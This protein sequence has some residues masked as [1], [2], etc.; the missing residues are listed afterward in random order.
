MLITYLK[1]LKISARRYNSLIWFICIFSIISWHIRFFTQCFLFSSLKQS[2]S[3]YFN[4]EVIVLTWMTSSDFYFLFKMISLK[5]RV[6]LLSFFQTF[7]IS[8]QQV[9]VHLKFD[10]NNSI[11]NNKNQWHGWYHF[12]F[13]A[14]ITKLI[15]LFFAFS[16]DEALRPYIVAI[17]SLSFLLGLTWLIVALVVIYKTRYRY[18]HQ[19]SKHGKESIELEEAPNLIQQYDDVHHMVVDTWSAEYEPRLRW[20]TGYGCRRKLHG[21][22]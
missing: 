22:K 10:E 17:S 4:V 20:W 21:Y 6:F 1:F 2:T 8:K 16:D 19:K 3:N 9:Y 13:K 11:W 7:T 5:N 15:E 12:F 18:V 14:K